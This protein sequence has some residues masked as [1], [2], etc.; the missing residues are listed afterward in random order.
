MNIP[1]NY[2]KILKNLPVTGQRKED[3]KGKGAQSEDR[4]KK[5]AQQTA[6][7]SNQTAK[8]SDNLLKSIDSLTQNFKILLKDVEANTLGI[9]K[10]VAVQEKLGT[11]FNNT[12][13]QITFLEQRNKGLN[14]TFGIS[15]EKAA[16]L[17]ERY[18]FVAK[19]L[20][21]GGKQIRKYAQ[22]LSRLLPLQQQNISAFPK[23]SSNMAD[24]GKQLLSVNQ[25][26]RENLGM[27]QE[28]VEGFARFAATAAD[29][30]IGVK[31]IAA[32]TTQYV[33]KLEEVTGLQGTTQA[34]LG[35]I[36][37]LASDVQLN[38]SKYPRDLGL[39]V[40][41]TR[42]LGTSLGEVYSIGKNLL[43]IE[44]SVGNELE[45]QLLSGKRLVNA[46]GESLTQ[47][48]R[49]ATLSGDANA[50]ADALN[51]IIESQGD[52]IK[53]NFFARKQLAETLGIGEDK[54]SKMVQQRELLQDMGPG[55]EKI[56]KMQGEELGAEIAKFRK[57]SKEDPARKA[58][59]T[60]V[61]GNANALTTDEKQLYYLEVLTT[62]L[63]GRQV[64]L[65]GK[66]QA[67]IVKEQ[68]TLLAD[69]SVIEDQVKQAERT[70]NLS[71]DEL[72]QGLDVLGKTALATQATAEN[73]KAI[74][75]LIPGF[76][77]V[78]NA[79]TALQDAA[80]SNINTL[81]GSTE[82]PIINTTP[83]DGKIDQDFLSR[84]GG[85]KI[86]FSSK[87]TI[88]GAKPGGPID[89]MLASSGGGG[90]SIDYGKIASA[91]AAA[92]RN[93]Q[94]VAPT[95]IYRDSSMNIESIT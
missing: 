52:T 85:E 17:G 66:S 20:N 22:E 33:E 58:F 79:L 7:I 41:K 54:L 35:G 16:D 88:V 73:T 2:I 14:K 89:Q 90:A 80:F 84:P 36:A 50:S 70:N 61:K 95:D 65:E 13:K 8:T 60:L 45:Y 83:G 91:M 9:S 82:A 77:K 78:G 18:D 68:Q 5:I 51:E 47:K 72:V 21:T 75:A 76:D 11:T 71:E 3:Q 30:A 31:D 63:I 81:Q 32:Q 4:A 69:P 86:S 93:V 27:S 34:I 39:A 37:G 74:Y 23:G 12:T 19:S 92:M 44:Q 42:M 40:L 94:I 6:N 10:Y 57:L 87:D 55:A 29:G 46:Q 15:S 26:F 56:M 1:Y 67:Q 64:K 49:E 59:E 53:D 28:S 38:F 43:N 62:G 25:I 24:F 48:F